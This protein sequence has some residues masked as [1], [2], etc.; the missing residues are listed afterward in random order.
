MMPLGIHSEAGHILHPDI[1][2]DVIRV[3]IA[4]VYLKFRGIVTEYGTDSCTGYPVAGS[5]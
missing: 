5:L 3:N 2:R 1:N 4:V